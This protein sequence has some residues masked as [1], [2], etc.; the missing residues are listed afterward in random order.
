MFLDI[1]DR[2]IS[3]IKKTNGL[4]TVWAATQFNVYMKLDIHNKCN[5]KLL[6]FRMLEHHICVWNEYVSVMEQEILLTLKAD[7]V[8]YWKINAWNF[9]RQDLYLYE[10]DK[11]YECVN[12]Q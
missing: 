3:V 6:Q 12:F 11:V 2:K 5:Y 9:C 1:Q 8:T 10:I 7:D 4:K